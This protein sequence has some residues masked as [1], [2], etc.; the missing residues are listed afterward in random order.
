MTTAAPADQRIP[1]VVAEL[2]ASG[3]GFSFD[4]RSWVWK[5]YRNAD[6]SLKDRWR[7]NFSAIQEYLTASLGADLLSEAAGARANT[8]DASA[9]GDPAQSTAAG[10][11]HDTGSE[12]TQARAPPPSL[13][14]AIAQFRSAIA[15]VGL[16]PP[17]TIEADGEVHR[18][19]S[20]GK[21]GDDAGWYVL[22]GDG[23]PAGTFGCW[24]LGISENWNASAG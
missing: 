17:D 3:E 6:Q 12:E 24:R 15:G 5:G 10:N 11:G 19:A 21:R 22:H 9:A 20:N 16:T 18:F 1:A 4:G 7:F 13:H 2:A 14:D 8:V 23:L